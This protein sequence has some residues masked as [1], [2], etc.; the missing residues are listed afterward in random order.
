MGNACGCAEGKTGEAGA[1][2]IAKAIKQGSNFSQQGYQSKI[3]P[4]TFASMSPAD[5][6]ILL[7][8]VFKIVLT[9][10]DLSKA[11]PTNAHIKTLMARSLNKFTLPSGE[12]FEG[13]VID[14][15]ANGKGKSIFTNGD[16]S[17]YEGNF[18]GGDEQG[19]GTIKFKN[20]DVLKCETF[21]KSNPYGLAQ[22]VYADKSEEWQCYNEKGQ[23]TGPFTYTDKDGMIY[24]GQYKGD[25]EDGIEVRIPKKQDSLALVDYKQGVAGPEKVFVLAGSGAPIPAPAPVVPVGTAPAATTTAA[26]KK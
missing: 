13:E 21:N 6:D 9:Q 25:K 4:S 8:E 10:G 5:K 15:I 19:Q 17:V 22:Y 18:T 11:K 12:Q 2:S 26:I 23:R 16:G 7:A 20:G 24:Y 3:A 1:S 14:G